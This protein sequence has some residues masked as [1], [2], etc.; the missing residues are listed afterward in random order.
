MTTP[1]R[2]RTAPTNGTRPTP[3]PNG[4]NGS[5]AKPSMNK[6]KAFSAGFSVP[7]NINVNA[8]KTVNGAGP[9]GRRGGGVSVESLL[10]EPDFTSPAAVRAYCAHLQALAFSLGIEIAMAA[11]ILE[12]TLKEVPDPDRRIGGSRARARKVARKLRKGADAATGLAKAAAGTHQTF[13]QEFRQEI[14]A[15]RHRARPRQRVQID[16][17]QQ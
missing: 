11:E 5:Q 1:P 13:T 12:A 2:P 17:A 10:P 6:S 14:E 4:D 7:L 9:T 16:W 8:N 15:V 3:P